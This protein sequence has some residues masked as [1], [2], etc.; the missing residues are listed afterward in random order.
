MSSA[1]SAVPS[2]SDPQAVVPFFPILSVADVPKARD[3]YTR[4]GFEVVAELPG[5]DGAL[6]R[7]I[8]RLGELKVHVVSAAAL[9]EEGDRGRSIERGPRG[10]GVILY[11]MVDDVDAAFDRVRAGGVSVMH[12]PRDEFWGHRIF[13]FVDPFGFDWVFASPLARA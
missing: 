5:P 2:P 4:L 3:L 10:L 7:V 8:L 1:S 11:A 13:R 12:A 6:H 9:P